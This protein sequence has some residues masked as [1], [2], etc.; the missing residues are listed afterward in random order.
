MKDDGHRTKCYGA[1]KSKWPAG[2]APAP[3]PTP[4]PAPTPVP[5]DPYHLTQVAG[6]SWMGSLQ[7]AQS[8]GGRLPTYAEAIAYIQKVGKALVPDFN[9]WVAVTNGAN[10]E[11]DW[12]AISG[13]P[14]PYPIGSTLVG[15]GGKPIFTAWFNAPSSNNWVLWVS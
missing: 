14:S 1:D 5:K 10:N 7:Y 3:T 8:Q 9:Q 13:A 11:Y 6:V 12:I 15:A 4:A 2:P